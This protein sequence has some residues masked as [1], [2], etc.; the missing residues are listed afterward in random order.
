MCLH[1]KHLLNEFPW[2]SISTN[3]GLYGLTERA[4]IFAMHKRCL[5]LKT[6]YL[7]YT[8]DLKKYTMWELW[9]KFSGA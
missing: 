5:Q 1:I 8:V 7:I 6:R 4:V 3:D 2:N 9:V